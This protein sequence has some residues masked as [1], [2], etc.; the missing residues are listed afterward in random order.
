MNNARQLPKIVNVASVPQ[1]SP[2]R[3]PG[4]KTWL[5]PYLRAWLKSLPFRPQLFVEPFLGGGIISLTVGFE[6]LADEV[7]MVELDEDVAAVWRAILGKDA[8]WL[9]SRIQSFDISVDNVRA[10]LAKPVRSVRQRAFNTILKNRTFH[11]GILAHGA[12]LLKHGENGKGIKSR[13]YADTLC[14]RISNISTIRDRFDFFQEDG[15]D[16]IAQR[17][18]NPTTV[19]FIDPPYTAGGNGK[20]AGRRLYKYSELDHGKLFDVACQT[21]GDFLMTYDNDPEVVAMAKQMG[22]DTAV[23][24]MKNTHHA[25]MVEL[26]IGKNLQWARSLFQPPPQQALF[27]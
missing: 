11:G 21:A 7:A 14:E 17:A 10:E 27:D 4:G 13:W 23:V 25:E 20:R 1:R 9:A 12:G 24:P 16:F 22:F 8:K 5:V 15:I 6:Q 3:Y 26:L 18:T 2:F 19:F